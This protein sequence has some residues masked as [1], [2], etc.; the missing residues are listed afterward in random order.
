MRRID[1]DP[2]ALDGELAQWF[3]RWRERSV[4]ATEDIC[5]QKETSE[6]I[7][8]RDAIWRDLKEWLLKHVFSGKCA[9]CEGKYDAQSYGAADH[10]RPKGRVTEKSG[11]PGATTSEVVHSGY[12]W[13][14]Y[15]WINIVP[16]CDKCNSGGKADQ[17][18]IDGVRVPHHADFEPPNDFEELD[19]IE[20][21]LLL[22]PYRDRPDEH[23]IFGVKGAIA[24]LEGS[25]KGAVTIKV[26]RLDR[27]ELTDERM[28]RQEHARSSVAK[29]YRLACDERMSLDDALTLEVSRYISA[30]ARYS[31][32]ALAAVKEVINE[33]NS[34]GS[35]YAA[36]LD[37]ADARD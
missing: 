8:F 26:C 29:A 19:R 30:D 1:F 6:K 23:L 14:A 21:P 15:H 3:A 10:Y 31:A 2:D 25:R 22:H 4:Q 36:K 16:A 9:Y 13:L 5:H 20:Q 27:A 7:Q 35:A 18:P 28:E 12:Y 11:D 33:L 37:A 32:A 24:P 17:F 34:A